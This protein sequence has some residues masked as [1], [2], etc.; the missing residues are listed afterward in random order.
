MARARKTVIGTLFTK[1]PLVGTGVVIGI[2]FLAY[3]GLRKLFAP[4]SP[5]RPRITGGTATGLPAGWSPYP[6]AAKLKTEMSG[7]SL[8]YP[9]SW[10]TLADLPTDA[11]VIAVY[12]AFNEQYFN[13]GDGTLVE[14]IMAEWQWAGTTK[15]QALTRLSSLQLP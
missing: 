2:G 4:A 5:P 8:T 12:N 11:M 1:N 9:G 15:Q 7:L 10:R 3:L 13:L 14:W 6:L